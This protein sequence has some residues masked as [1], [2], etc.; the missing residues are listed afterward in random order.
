M[1]LLYQIHTKLG[2]LE[3]DLDRWIKTNWQRAI[4]LIQLAIWPEIP[5]AAAPPYPTHEAP[6]ELMI[7]T[8]AAPPAL[9]HKLPTELMIEILLSALEGTDW[10]ANDLQHLASVCKYWRDII[11]DDSHFW[12]VVDSRHSRYSW[13][14]VLRRNRAG[15]L[16][17]HIRGREGRQ[18]NIDIIAPLLRLITPES[19]RIRSLSFVSYRVRKARVHRTGFHTYRRWRATPPPQP[20]QRSHF[21]EHDAAA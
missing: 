2:Q 11:L 3:K 7:G 17:V 19:Q 18:Y 1:G 5:K 21:L 6:T 15:P 9:I 14:F 10:S 16:D 13:P 8:V 20:R 12:R 4:I